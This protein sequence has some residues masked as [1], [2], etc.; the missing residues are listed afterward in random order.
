[1]VPSGDFWRRCIVIQRS[2]GGGFDVDCD[3]CQYVDWIDEEYMEDVIRAIKSEGWRIVKVDH[4][5]MHACPACAPD[6]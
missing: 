4:K 6:K 2:V 1:M 3:I 5:F